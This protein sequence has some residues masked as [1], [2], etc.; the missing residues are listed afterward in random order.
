MG[1]KTWRIFSGSSS[2]TRRSRDSF[3]DERRTFL[4]FSIYAQGLPLLVCIAT[5]ITDACRE[6][7]HTGNGLIATRHFPNMGVVR[8][9][10][11]EMYADRTTYLGSA[12]FLYNDMFMVAIQMLNLYFYASICVVLYK[13]WENQDSIRRMKG[14]ERY[15]INWAVLSKYF[16]D[17]EDF[18]ERIARHKKHAVVCLRLFIILGELFSVKSNSQENL[19]LFCGIFQVC[20]GFWR[21]YPQQF[22]T[23]I[24]AMRIGG[25]SSSWILPCVL[26]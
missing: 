4:Y 21:W 18:Q 17:V 2:E 7:K 19:A 8:C 22:L 26:Q 25:Q 16:R 20:L 10:V 24:R 5:A 23:K 3:T 9:F 1:F 13:G 15:F 12:K 11:G 6:R 14:F